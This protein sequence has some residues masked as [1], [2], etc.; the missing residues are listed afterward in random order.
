[1]TI[2]EADGYSTQPLT[3]DSLEIFAGELQQCDPDDT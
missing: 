1:M 2:I 3:V